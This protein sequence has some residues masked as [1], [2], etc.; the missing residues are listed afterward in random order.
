MSDLYNDPDDF[1]LDEDDFEE[2]D[3]LEEGCGAYELHNPKHPKFKANYDK[4]M[5]KNPDSSL[6]DFINAQK[7][8]EYKGGVE[9]AYTGSYGR[10]K[11]QKKDELGDLLRLRA[12]ERKDAGEAPGKHDARYLAQAKPKTRRSGQEHDDMQRESIQGMIET[13]LSGNL[14]ESTQSFSEIISAKIAYRLEESKIDVAKKVFGLQESDDHDDDDNDHDDYS[15]TISKMKKPKEDDDYKDEKH[16][17][18]DDDAFSKS[19]HGKL[20]T[21]E[22]ID[23]NPLSDDEKENPNDKRVQA[24]LAARAA[25]GE[26]SKPNAHRDIELRQ[27]SVTLQHGDAKRINNFMAGLKP[28]KR[29]EVMAHMQ[30]SPKHFEAVHDVVKKFPAPKQNTSIYKDPRS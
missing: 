3:E 17:E 11:K 10:P 25:K 13:I 30:K 8:K 15:K 1:D 19:L 18:V 27:G 21:A 20:K 6:K 22:D 29:Q 2:E 5:K 26:M 23:N 9:E 7:A 28:Q 24:G 4:F 14:V 16:A 12:Q